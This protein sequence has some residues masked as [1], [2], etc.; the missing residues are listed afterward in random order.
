MT[1]ASV[2]QSFDCPGSTRRWRYD[3]QGFIEVEG[4]GTPMLAWPDQIER[5]R[6]LIEQSAAKYG[7][8]AAWVAS[9]MA[10]ETGGRNVCL[11]ASN[12]SRA[13][14]PPCNCVQNEGA[15][16]MAMQPSTASG[17]AGR[18]VTSQELL[19]NPALAI[20]LGAKLI[21]ANVD[22][23]HGEFVHAALSY[24]AGSVRCGR[25][26]TFV[27][28]GRDWPREPCPDTGWGVIMGCVYTDRQYGDRC[29]PSSTGVKPYV[30]STDYPMH[31][32]EAQNAARVHFDGQAPPDHPVALASVGGGKGFA[33]LAAA[34]LFGYAA[35]ALWEAR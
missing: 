35:V 12:P 25:G 4:V 7:I 15:G 14:S 13:C 8:P 20:D 9:T 21:A 11:D 31:A 5:W 2:W 22:K 1:V 23:Y 34:A 3:D 24:N 28:S 26:Q 6:P 27:P 17:L 19:D 10:Q 30:C 18:S 29:G 33:Y 16:V 32:I